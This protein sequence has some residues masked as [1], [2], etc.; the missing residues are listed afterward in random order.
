M[1]MDAFLAE[2]Y[3]TNKTASAPQEDLEKQATVDL[4]IKLAAEQNIDLGKMPDAQVQQLYNGFV[5]K[6]ASAPAATKTAEEEKEEHEKE[7][8]KKKLEEAKKEHEEKHAMSKKADEADAMGRIMAHAYVQELRKIAAAG[9][10][11]PVATTEGQEKE[12]DG[13]LHAGLD[14]LK[15]KGRQAGAGASAF[16]KH[17]KEHAHEPVEEAKHTLKSRP[18]V[19]HGA[20]AAAGAGAAHAVHE[21]HKHGSAL[22]ELAAEHAVRL[23][24]AEGYDAEEAGQKIAALLTLGVEESTKIASVPD[25]PSAIGVRALEFLEKVGY[26]VNWNTEAA[27]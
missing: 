4:F 16:G 26:Q 3:G 18:G 10:A 22:D 25:L 15:H 5:E 8:H 17:I 19:T 9:E 21:H 27:K 23:A 20:A 13:K 12:A 7:E 14:W 2:Y 11:T 6:L 1:S 24:H